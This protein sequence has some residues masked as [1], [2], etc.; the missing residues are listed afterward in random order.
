MIIW[1]INYFLLEIYLFRNA[2]PFG[3]TKVSQRE[4]VDLSKPCLV[5][6]E[7][8]KHQPRGIVSALGGGSTKAVTKA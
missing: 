6:R 4:T 8:G 3:L 5:G 2:R 7:Q 1:Y